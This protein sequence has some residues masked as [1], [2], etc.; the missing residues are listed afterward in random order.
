MVPGQVNKLDEDTAVFL[1]IYHSLQ[2]TT[3]FTV[4]LSVPYKD[5]HVRRLPGLLQ[6]MA[7]MMGYVFKERGSILQGINGSMSFTVMNIQHISSSYL[8]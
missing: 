6:K 8:A 4:F 1:Q 5:A 3:A 7:R 2:W